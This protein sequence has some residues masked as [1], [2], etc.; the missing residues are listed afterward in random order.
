MPDDP[1]QNILGRL[2][3][4]KQTAPNQWEAR[5][6]AHDDRHASLSVCAGEDGRA[7]VNCHAGCS[8]DD[9]RQALKLP[10]SAFFPPRQRPDRRIITTYDYTD[11]HG[12]LLYQVLRFAGKQFRQRR[13]DGQ[14][15]WTWKLSGVPR[16]LYRLPQ[17]IAA[18]E[19]EPVLIAEGEKDVDNLVKLG[20]VATCNPGGAGK[21]KHLSDDSALHGRQVVI[22]PDKDDPGRKHA[23]DVAM[24]LCN[25][26]ANVRVLEMPG[27]GVKDASDWI[28]AG[29]TAEQL[30][31]LVAA[32]PTPAPP[33]PATPARSRPKPTDAPAPDD[34]HTD[35]QVAL[36][37]R[38]PATG[39]LVLSPRRTLP[40]A[41]A[42]VDQYHTHP[43]GRTL[44]GYAGLL[45]AWRDNRYLQLEDESLRHALQ[46]WL[47]EAMRYVVNRQTGQPELVDFESNPGTVN[48]ALDSIR[49]Y[50][51]LPAT[52][53]MPSWLDGYRAPC[54]AREVLPCRTMNLHIPTGN[55]I[56]ATPALFTGNALDFD[57]NPDAPPP[58][59]WLEFLDQLW[60][61]DP[62]QI[63]TLQ[64]WFGYC[65][66]ADTSQHKILLM[67]G[68]K[69]SGKG[70]I[71]RVL[72]KLVGASNVVGPTTGSLAG[73]F[74]LQP[75]IGKSL[76]IVSDARFT[77]ENVAVV[78]ERLLCISGEDMLTIDR[79]FLASVSM[80]LPTR[81]MLLTNELPRMS[82]ASGA[83]A[84][85]FIMLR[86]TKSFYGR[87]DTGLTDRLTAELPGILLWAIDGWMRLRERGHFVQP[88]SVADAV[89]DMEDLA[90]PVMAFVRDCCVVGPGQRAWVDDLYQAWKSWC[91]REGRSVTTTR[92]TFGRDLCAA[93][94]GVST[95][96]G[97]GLVRFYQGI[98]LQGGTP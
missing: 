84:G 12:E 67:V 59:A 94:P 93:V 9:V 1:V 85:R 16:V 6:P 28:E 90:S 46:P 62:E 13:P 87:E 54:D 35:G 40:T 7:L 91:E 21:W 19:S 36:G 47:H 63:A 34:E 79:K 70:T 23:Q 80:K 49:S 39:R 71:G 45:L 97:T 57:Y 11:A 78:V 51:Y 22:I 55:V 48:S 4:V 64:E 32:A 3:G 20:F 68:P 72:T 30:R 53:P 77:G 92:Q 82:D 69:R 56:P 42:Y 37:S 52:T 88:A 2:E 98:G 81:F 14:G 41:R 29:G 74:G 83:L 73:A 10:W 95:R 18:Q 15:G 61:N 89:Q 50:V 8:R 26:A 33:V 24:R 43:D 60:G 44:H 96:R 65:L 66:T 27:E 86:L 5:C 17:L 25:R 38:D 58:V 31:A 76:A 75:L